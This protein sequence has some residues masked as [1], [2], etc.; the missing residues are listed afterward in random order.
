MQV[1]ETLNEGL[2]REYEISV[3]AEAIKEKTEQR[4][5]EIGK[6]AKISG[7]RPG[8]VPVSVLKRQYGKAV[9]GEVLEGLVNESTQSLIKDKELR[10]ALDPKIEVKSFE[11]EKS[12]EF[13][14]SVELVPDFEPMDFST[15]SLERPVVPVADKDIDESLAV[16]TERHGKENPV[17]VDRKADKGDIVVM[18]FVGS[19]DG[20]EFPGGA[21]QDFSLELGSGQF[22]PG[23]ED[24]LVGSE[25]GAKVDVT[26]NFPEDYHAN[27][28]AGKEAVF[29]CEILA[30]KEAAKVEVD[31]EFA[32]T[33]GFD[34]VAAIR[35]AIS[36]RI[37][38][39]YSQ[40]AR[41]R[42]KRDLLD[43]LAEAHDFDLPEGLVDQEFKTIWEQVKAEAEKEDA[44]KEKMEKEYREIAIRRVRLGLL[45][46]EVGSKNK[47]EITEEDMNKA[48]I[49]E[50]QRYPGQEKQVIEFFQ[51][52]RDAQA[53][54]RAPI[55]EDKVVDFILEL[56]KVSDKET[57][58][59]ELTKSLQEDEEKS[60]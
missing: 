14:M 36:D 55:Y 50:I 46:S 43:K 33:L 4:L 56:A 18:N 40:V 11:E 31:D 13:T 6:T 20:T 23:F 34:D 52:N 27:D 24:Q 9:M 59:E 32:K 57:T 58:M 37:T 45:L 35:K 17:E 3:A 1:T 54:L 51:N 49:Q 48:L 41:S 10:L 30:V 25:A 12:L 28:L 5:K 47:I 60:A 16:M 26:V 53:R 21:G 22:I 39:E 19:I 2:K 42:V 8:K 15:L 38:E 29:A 44:D 7:F